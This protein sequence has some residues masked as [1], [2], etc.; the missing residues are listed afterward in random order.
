MPSGLPASLNYARMSSTPLSAS[1]GKNKQ[2]QD[3]DEWENWS[4]YSDV[5][6]FTMCVLQYGYNRSSSVYS[7][8]HVVRSLTW[9]GSLFACIHDPGRSAFPSA[10]CSRSAK[11]RCSSQSPSSLPHPASLDTPEVG[12]ELTEAWG[13][14]VWPR[15]P[16]TGTRTPRDSTEAP[17]RAAAG[18]SSN[19]AP[20]SVPSPPS[21][22]ESPEGED[23]SP[24]SPPGPSAT[25]HPVRCQSIFCT[26]KNR[27]C[28]V[29]ETK[30]PV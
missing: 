23:R 3:C 10:V 4:F 24:L 15:P 19:A 12:G 16:W 6:C 13:G 1:W 29:D 20:V 11:T 26:R 30:Q 7:S 9:F 22:W 17:R 21:C 27:K 14:S 5:P 18:Q 28:P 25:G 8:P 2:T